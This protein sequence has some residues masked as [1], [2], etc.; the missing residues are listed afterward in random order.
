LATLLSGSILITL[1][2]LPY[3]TLKKGAD[4]LAKDGNLE[5]FHST[6]Y[7]SWKYKILGL[8]L[9]LLVAGIIWSLKR[10]K[11]TGLIEAGLTQSRSLFTS[12]RN[13]IQA[14]VQFTINIERNRWLLVTL[15]C[16]TVFAIYLRV[17][18]LSRPIDYDE[19]YT[20]VVFASRPFREFIS[21]YHLPN[22]HVFHTILV[23]LA[24][25]VFGA[26]LWAIRLPA[27]LAGILIIPATYMVARLHYDSLTGLLSTALVTTSSILIDSSTKARGYSMI[28]LFTLLLLALSVFLLQ[29][30]NR[31]AWAL[32]TLLAALGVYTI[33]IMLYPI[34]IALGWLFLSVVF[35]NT[36]Q[37]STNYIVKN[38]VLC[39]FFII[40]L[41]FLFYLPIIKSSGLQALTGNRFVEARAWSAFI[42]SIPGRI[43]ATWSEWFAEVPAPISF[44]LLTGVLVSIVFHQRL[45]N[46]RVHLIVPSLIW[47]ALMLI[48][49]RVVG[50]PRVWLFLLPLFFVWASAGIVGLFGK[51]PFGA[52]FQPSSRHSTIMLIIILIFTISSGWAVMSEKSTRVLREPGTFTDAEQTALFLKEQLHDGDV[53]LTTTPVNYPIRY[54]FQSNDIPVQYF[55]KG[56]YGVDFQRAFVVVSPT[57][58][59]TITG[60]LDHFKLLTILDQIDPLVV[61][62]S[63][64]MVIY[65]LTNP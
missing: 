16:I 7:T 54:Y 38:L 57:Y 34:G 26:D 49:Q 55:Y 18:F 11:A 9:M 35:K 14:L 33:P 53:V 45:S 3:A 2:L 51:I 43:T 41:S 60:V 6:I 64:G 63:Q 27:F 10:T 13:D 42:E 40:L 29:H 15:A 31:V 59:Q 36:N 23:H 28:C 12:I 20:F 37:L 62:Q 47:I 52:H 17:T 19:A 61:Y 22:N 1:S 24:Y 46:Q 56:S 44:F 50:W 48:V 39:S 25:Q 58:S 30:K 8:G 21:D 32:L 5:S 65:Q 4:A